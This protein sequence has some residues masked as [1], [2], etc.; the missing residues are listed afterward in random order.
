LLIV[1]AS[2]R[3]K[4]SYL[5]KM[6]LSLLED[7]GDRLPDGLGQGQAKSPLFNMLAGN[8]NKVFPNY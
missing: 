2:K 5:S 1:I 7:F 4:I 3:A 8:S 6:A